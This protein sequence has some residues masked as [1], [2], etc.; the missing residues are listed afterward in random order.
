M[1]VPCHA[2]LVMPLVS[3]S[4]AELGIVHVKYNEP[5]CLERLLVWLELRENT[6]TL[7]A[8]K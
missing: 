6:G 4:Q 2:I 1:A 8:C 5:Q 7:A 3:S